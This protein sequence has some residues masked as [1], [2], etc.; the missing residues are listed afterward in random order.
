VLVELEVWPN[1]LNAAHKRGVPVVLINARMPE[2]EARRYRAG[3]IFFRRVF[4]RLALVVAQEQE[5]TARFAKLGVPADR[6]RVAGNLKFDAVPRSAHFETARSEE[7]LRREFGLPLQAQIL[8]AGSTHAGEEEVLLDVAAGLRSEWPGLFPVLVPRHTARAGSI[9]AMAR[10]RGFRP[11]LRSRLAPQPSERQAHDCL[12]VDTMGELERL[13]GLAT[14][15]FVGKSLCGRGGQNIV[16]AAAGGSPVIF[17]PHMQNFQTVARQFLSSGAAVQV[18]DPHELEVRLRE[19]LRDSQLRSTIG[20][21]AVRL[22]RANQGGAHQT[23]EWFL[24][25]LREGDA[26]PT[27]TNSIGNGQAVG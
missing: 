16:E 25:V 8:V 7:E 17:G 6:L 22:I 4:A 3:L 19:L 24:G 18:R 27:T 23:V 10:A 2:K 11:A 9:M 1:L 14:V 15:V 21:S 20:D 5:D 13:Y 12:V 26:P